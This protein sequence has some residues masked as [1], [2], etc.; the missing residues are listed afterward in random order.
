MRTGLP[1][2][3]SSAFYSSS[4][5]QLGANSEKSQERVGQEDNGGTITLACPFTHHTDFPSHIPGLLS[6]KSQDQLLTGQLSCSLAQSCRL[7]AVVIGQGHR[8][9]HMPGRLD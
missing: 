4:P 5:L 2:E 8:A 6:Q 1:A 7:P 3:D 9:E